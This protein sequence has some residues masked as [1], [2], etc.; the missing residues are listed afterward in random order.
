M[1]RIAQLGTDIEV[2]MIR[3]NLR[4]LWPKL[5][6][7]TLPFITDHSLLI[8]ASS[9]VSFSLLSIDHSLLTCLFV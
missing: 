4:N 1:P 2:K 6:I 9:F 7:M 3:V 8:M 5:N